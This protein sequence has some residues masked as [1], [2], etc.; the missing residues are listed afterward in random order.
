MKVYKADEE[1]ENILYSQGFV[2]TTPKTDKLKR[3]KR[4]RI[5]KRSR[6]EIIFDWGDIRIRDEMF[7][8]DSKREITEVELKLL[9]LFCKLRK[10][11]WEKVRMDGSFAFKDVNQRINSVK[12]ELEIITDIGSLKSLK[13][14][15]EFIVDMYESIDLSN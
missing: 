9:I 5:S 11:D 3:K 6:K 12:N 10:A 7:I 8:L 15:L 13:K 14:R 1:L 2:V 4:F